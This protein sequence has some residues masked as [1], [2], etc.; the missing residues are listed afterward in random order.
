MDKPIFSDLNEGTLKMVEKKYS[1]GDL[2][3]FWRLEDSFQK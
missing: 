1:Q 2:E 3:R